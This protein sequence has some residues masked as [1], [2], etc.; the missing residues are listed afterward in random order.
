[1]TTPP[2]QETKRRAPNWLGIGVVALLLIGIVAVLLL[3][4][5]AVQAP[6]ILT[7]APRAASPTAT[8]APDVFGIQPVMPALRVQ[9]FALDAALPD[10][11]TRELRLSELN[12]RYVLLFFGYTHCPDFCPLTLTEFTQIKRTLGDAAA[13]VRFLFISVDGARDT[14]DVMRAY[15][16]R[17]DADFYGMSGDEATLAT[18]EADYGLD[19]ILRTDEGRGDNYLVDHTTSSYLIDQDGRLVVSYDYNAE[20]SAIAADISARMGS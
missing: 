5:S 6:P 16:D 3:R 4:P 11:E 18:I 1:M 9:D 12:D 2:P 14:P 19:Y 8:F 17:F 10:G 15:L 20:P 7:A 13:R